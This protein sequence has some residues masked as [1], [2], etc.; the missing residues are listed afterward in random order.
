MTLVSTPQT[1][2]RVGVARRDITPPAG[3]YHRMWGAAMHDRAEGVHK[4]CWPRFFC[5]I[6][7]NPQHMPRMWW[8]RSIIAFSMDVKSMLCAG[9]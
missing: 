3:I 9:P 7:R 5:S 2:C 4:P 6:R 1:R 8:F